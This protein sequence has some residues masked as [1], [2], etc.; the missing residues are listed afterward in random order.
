MLMNSSTYTSRN[1]LF[2]KA[3]G[4]PQA[5]VA[6]EHMV[7]LKML[8]YSWSKISQMLGISRQTLYRQLKEC[9]IST[10]DFSEILPQELDEIDGEIMLGMPTYLKCLLVTSSLF[11]IHGTLSFRKSAETMDMCIQGSFGFGSV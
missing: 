3:V 1:I 6:K 5:N 2:H 11:E 9:N 8:N 4:Q 7:D 10:C